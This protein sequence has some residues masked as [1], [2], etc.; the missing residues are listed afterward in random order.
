MSIKGV[1]NALEALPVP[2]QPVRVL[3][4]FVSA[5]DALNRLEARRA[6]EQAAEAQVEV[7]AQQSRERGPLEM[8]RKL[9]DCAGVSPYFKRDEFKE[10]D[11]LALRILSFWFGDDYDGHG[12]SIDQYDLWFGKSEETDEHIRAKFKEYLVPCADGHY[13]HWAKHP[14][15]VVALAILMDQF[16][17]NIYRNSPRSFSYDWKAL[18][19]VWP[20]IRAGMDDRLQVFERVWL[21]LV[22]T[23][24]EDLEVQKKCVELGTTKLEEMDENWKKMWIVIFEKHRKVIEDF[25]RFPHR[26]VQMYRD[27]T[28]EEAEFVKDESFRFDLPVQCT[29][30]PVTGKPKFVFVAPGTAPPAAPA[31][32]VLTRT[33]SVPQEL[34]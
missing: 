30:D 21:Y 16:P 5:K 15:G 14:L 7:D 26:N 3:V 9:L 22:F 6:L 1:V 34:G 10:L 25:G 11:A 13:D 17:R 19:T 20:A 4:H 27:S 32:P 2:Q 31:E 29:I 12:V 23:H 8:E 18:A 33:G 24:A 28:E